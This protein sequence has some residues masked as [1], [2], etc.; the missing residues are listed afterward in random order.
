[1]SFLDI[2]Y[3]IIH[4]INARISGCTAFGD[5][6]CPSKKCILRAKVCDGKPDCED[7]SDEKQSCPG[8]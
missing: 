6:Q 2:M 1:M 8:Q 7:G 3:L 5:F 4:L